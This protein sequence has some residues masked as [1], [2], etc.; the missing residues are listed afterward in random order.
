MANI[1]ILWPNLVIISARFPTHDLS[2]Y[3]TKNVHIYDIIKNTSPKIQ[4]LMIF[5]TSSFEI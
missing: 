2:N 3:L 4:V 5:K 1:V